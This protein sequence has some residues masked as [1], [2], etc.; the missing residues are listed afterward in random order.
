[1]GGSPAWLTNYNSAGS[2]ER[3]TATRCPRLSPQSASAAASGRGVPYS[4]LAWSG[5]KRSHSSRASPSCPPPAPHR[6]AQRRE[7]DPSPRLDRRARDAR[8]GLTKQSGEPGAQQPVATGGAV[9][10]AFYASAR[11]LSTLILRVFFRMRV[12]PR[13]GVPAAGPLIVVANHESLLDGF[14]VASV[15]RS[16]RLTFLSASY[17][18]ELPIVGSFLRAI[19]ALPVQEQGHNLSSLRRA[20]EILKG[21][22]AVALF[23]QGGISGNEILGGAAYLALRTGAP[24]LPLHISGTREALPPGRRW[25]SLARIH[26]AAGVPL[27]LSNE[28]GE[29]ATRP[30]ISA[31]IEALQRV[32]SGTDAQS[33]DR[34]RGL[35]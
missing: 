20:I 7:A 21:G 17:L 5:R 29:A 18:Y 3:R 8:G 15:L 6:T 26:V 14:V 23:P 9:F 4:V 31:G 16:R 35:A 11:A 2:R 22:G 33:E 32:L 10:A 30:A 25:P 19:G 13:E 34:M 28:P 27:R 1:M 12:S 24:L